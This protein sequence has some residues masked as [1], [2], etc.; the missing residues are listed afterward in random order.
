M[1]D[2]KAV[3]LQARGQLVSA[4]MLQQSMFSF[5]CVGVGLALGLQRKTLRPFIY[6]VTAGT[7]ADATYGY[8]FACREAIEDYNKCKAA[9]TASKTAINSNNSS[10]SS[11][12]SS[13]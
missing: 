11:S 2:K 7:L 8:M 13:K 9:D 10:S 1:T 12:S 6:A 5:L 3:S 4:C